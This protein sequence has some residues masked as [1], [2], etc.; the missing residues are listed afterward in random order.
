MSQSPIA[1]TFTP[2]APFD[3]LEPGVG[4]AVKMPE[5]DVMNM[6][7]F[8]PKSEISRQKATHL[9]QPSFHFLTNPEPVGEL[10]PSWSV[11]PQFCDKHDKFGIQIQL[12]EGSHCYGGGEQARNLCL[13]NTQWITWNTDAFAY[14]QKT[15]SL[16]Q[17]HPFILVVRKNGSSFGVIANSTYPLFFEVTNTHIKVVS[18]VQH[19]SSPIPFS[20][21]IFEAPTPQDITC[22]LAKLTGKIDLPP[23]WAIGY[24]QCR[25]SYYPDTRALEVAK[26]FRDKEIPCDVI[27]FDI[28]Y[29]NEYRIFTFDPYTFPEPKLL[30]DRLHEQ[31]FHSVWMIDPGIKKEEKYSVHDQ[32]VANDLAVHLNH[33]D[34]A[35]SGQKYFEGDVWPG[36]CIFPDFT[37]DQTRA[38]WGTLYKDFMNQGVDGVWNDMNEVA[39]FHTPTLTMDRSCWHRGFGGGDHERFHNV[40]GMMMIKASKEGIMKANPTKRPFLLSRSN[41]LGGQRYGATWTGDNASNWN[42]LALSIPMVLNLGISGQPFSGPDIGGFFKEATPTLFSRWMG[43]GAFFPFARAHTHEATVDHEPWSFGEECLN[44]C[45]TAIKRRYRLL[46][47]IYTAFY[48]ASKFGLP[49]ARPLFF[50]DPKD[51]A[52]RTEDRAFLLGDGVL[53]IANVEGPVKEPKIKDPVKQAAKAAKPVTNPVQA[54]QK[55][56]GAVPIPTNHTWYDLDLD[57]QQDPNLPIMKIRGGTI[58]AAREPE[59]FVGEKEFDKLIL[60][61]ALDK[62]GSASGELYLDAGE[63]L[64]YQTNGYLLIKF[65]GSLTGD[66]FTLDLASEGDFPRPFKSV[67]L[68]LLYQQKKV[69]QTVPLDT[70]QCCLS[71]EVN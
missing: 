12:E 46:P 32:C 43:F 27:W 21:L 8:Y 3:V 6:A 57:G 55:P 41:F 30:N 37:L 15:A 42:H 53:V 51:E 2:I 7:L 29:M 24:H 5:V 59:Q 16:Y 48:H 62:G 39:V 9:E 61:V 68:N 18:H 17:S 40:Y 14:S 64:D 67:E 23:L 19:S 44:T 60:H 58:V 65:S 11:R 10:P 25:W 13:N 45:R 35:T 20:V 54:Q 36:K 34:K 56:T 52:L 33:P 66:L 69:N 28:H 26:T 38:W 1:P 47:Y 70:N 50:V 22:N 71:V 4:H 49:V 31:G 63:G